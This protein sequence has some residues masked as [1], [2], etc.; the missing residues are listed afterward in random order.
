[1]KIGYARTSTMEQE[2]GLEAQIRDLQAA[3]CDRIY[4]EKVSSVAK[5]PQLDKVLAMVR[6][7]DVVVVTKLDRLA[8]NVQHMGQIITQIEREGA[9]L[10]ILNLGIDTTTPT[11]KLMLNIMGSVAQFERE[12]MLERQREGIAKAKAEGK[13][14]GRKP[15]SA[16]IV[17]K[18]L[19]LDTAEHGATFIARK[20]GIG[21]SSVYRVIEENGA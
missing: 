8:R 10:Q 5:R 2:A 4:D 20:V 13:Y 17:A 18:I 19:E 12:M 1:M 6:P 14:K 7:G 21:R 3:G 11:G 15:L 9:G 16:D